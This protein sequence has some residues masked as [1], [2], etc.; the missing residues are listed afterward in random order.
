MFNPSRRARNIYALSCITSPGGKHRGLASSVAVLIA[1]SLLMLWSRYIC[2][3]E[4]EFLKAQ[5]GRLSYVKLSHHC[6][7]KIEILKFAFILEKF[8]S[9]SKIGHRPKRHRFCAAFRKPCWSKEFLAS[10]RTVFN[11][12]CAWKSRILNDVGILVNYKLLIVSGVFRE[13]IGKPCRV[14]KNDLKSSAFSGVSKLTLHAMVAF[15]HIELP[16]LKCAPHLC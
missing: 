15:I 9:K 4:F 1:E 13:S 11:V 5:Q 8:A 3:T 6:I 7:V 2:I 16:M 14:G 12:Y 10:S